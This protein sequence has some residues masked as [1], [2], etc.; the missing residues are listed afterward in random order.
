MNYLI[1][2][3]A[4]IQLK[5]RGIAKK[6]VSEVISNPDT[7]TNID[8]DLVVYQKQMEE[9]DRNYLFRVFVNTNKTPPL[10]VTAYKTTKIDKYEDK[11]R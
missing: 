4:E 9:G 8:A 10:V 11:I 7:K 1:S 6:T 2:K 3:H 5:R